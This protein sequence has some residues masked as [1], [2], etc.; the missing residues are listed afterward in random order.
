M[1]LPVSTGMRGVWPAVFIETVVACV[2]G[3]GKQRPGTSYTREQ[4]YVRDV[5]LYG[6]GKL[7]YGGVG[8]V[9]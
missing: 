3:G 8:V 2:D 1:S 6:Q 4:R 9:G 5:H 7:Y